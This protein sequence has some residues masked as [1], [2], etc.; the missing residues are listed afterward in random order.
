MIQ[1]K[2]A[3]T[4]KKNPFNFIKSRQIAKAINL[5]LD[6]HEIS[7]K[8]I[9]KNEIDIKS[10]IRRREI[11]FEIYRRIIF[12][13]AFLM[14]QFIESDINTSKFIL[15]Y[16]VAKR[17]V[18][19]REFLHESYRVALSSEKKYISMDDFNLFFARKKESSLV[20][21]KWSLTTI[22]LLA[23]GYRKML[24]DS[25][26]GTRK[27]KNI[28]VN[29]LIIHPAVYKHIK[30]QGDYNFLQAILGEQ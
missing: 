22:G 25:N 24:C 27:L 12:L 16:A 29:K 7:E 14:K 9:L 18:L 20:V 3:S 21:N 23:K 8:F 6:L 19:F 4:I 13:D 15:I 10:P 11:V 30:D 5:G 28:L 17:D 26:L 2:I 1:S